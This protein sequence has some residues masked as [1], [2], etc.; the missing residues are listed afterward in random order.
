MAL[1]TVHHKTLAHVGERRT[2]DLRAGTPEYDR[3]VTVLRRLRCAKRKL[4]TSG[5]R[6]RDLPASQWAGWVHPDWGWV[7]RNVPDAVWICSRVAPFTRAT[8]REVG[9]RV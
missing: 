8:F 2:P 1:V 3:A 5:E 7:G 9:I 4:R 6:E